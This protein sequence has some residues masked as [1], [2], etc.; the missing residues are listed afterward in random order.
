MKRIRWVVLATMIGACQVFNRPDTP[1]TLR[2][3]NAGYVVE[4]TTIQETA[5]A[6]GTTLS[7]TAVAAETSIAQGSNITQ[8][9]ML[10]ARAIVPLTPTRA[11]VISGD[12]GTPAPAGQQFV[13]T[14]TASFVRDSDGCAGDSQTQFTT[15]SPRI[16]AT[17]R[18]QT[19]AAGT[20]MRVEWFFQGQTVWQESF[21]VS[22]DVNDF[23]I[24]FYIDPQ[25]VTFS[26]GGWTVRL[27]ANGT[28][29]EPEMTFTIADAMGEG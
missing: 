4:A 27:Y 20:Q 19:L 11:G 8:Q 1:A 16:Y 18:A 7:R 12:V 17:T 6:E 29:I 28:T 24:W 13:D 9:M 26:P 22:N 15:D 21:N 10:T 3:Q 23:C 5:R 2:A 25:T 14:H